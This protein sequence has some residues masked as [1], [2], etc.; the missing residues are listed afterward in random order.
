MLPEGSREAQNQATE[1]KA[2]LPVVTYPTPVCVR[3]HLIATMIHI[4]GQWSKY[5]K[6]AL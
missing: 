2:T 3:S 6:P 5:M 4:N 1:E